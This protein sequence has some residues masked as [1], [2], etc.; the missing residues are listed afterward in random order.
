MKK[1][2]GLYMK[3]L[4]LYNYIMPTKV[5]IIYLHEKVNFTYLYDKVNIIYHFIL[6][7][8]SDYNLNISYLQSWTK[9]WRHF[10]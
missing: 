9:H 3:K 7:T 2:I 1:L 5:N 8:K 10:S 6:L 4:T